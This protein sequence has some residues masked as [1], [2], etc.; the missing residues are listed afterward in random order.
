MNTSSILRTNPSEEGV[1][2]IIEL[3][4]EQRKSMNIGKRKVNV[5]IPKRLEKE[6][7]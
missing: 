1:G 5:K 6:R 4:N 3:R 7:S 2:R